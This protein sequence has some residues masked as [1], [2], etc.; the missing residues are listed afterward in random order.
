MLGICRQGRYNFCRRMR[1]RCSVQSVPHFQ[2]T[3]QELYL[4]LTSGSVATGT[5]MFLGWLAYWTCRWVCR[6]SQVR[7][8]DGGGYVRGHLLAGLDRMRNTMGWDNGLAAEWVAALCME[9]KSPMSVMTGTTKRSSASA[10]K[11]AVRQSENSLCTD[12]RSIP[13]GRI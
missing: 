10:W 9:P 11:V 6:L 1:F 2:G 12:R 4:I 5:R 7:L 8:E 13:R 3:L